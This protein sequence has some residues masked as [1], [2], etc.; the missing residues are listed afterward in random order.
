MHLKEF[1]KLVILIVKVKISKF[2][3][4]LKFDK[5]SILYLFRYVDQIL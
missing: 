2:S 4:T 3:N 1:E 5:K